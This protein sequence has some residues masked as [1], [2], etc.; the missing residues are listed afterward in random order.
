MTT[1]KNIQ[2]CMPW[3]FFHMSSRKAIVVFGSS[4]CE[5]D[6]DAYRTAEE[7]GTCLARSGYNVVTGGYSGTMEAVSKGA[8]AESSA[9]VCVRQLSL[10][11]L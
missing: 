1:T 4:T 6:S 11:S 3:N 8:S 10:S 9:I 7:L 5:T 2:T